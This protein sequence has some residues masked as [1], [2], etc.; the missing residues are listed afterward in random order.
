[1]NSVMYT[2]KGRLRDDLK[3]FEKESGLGP[4]DDR[5]HLRAQTF[6]LVQLCKDMRNSQY[7]LRTKLTRQGNG[8]QTQ[9]V[10]S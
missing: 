6:L 1:M 10:W 4:D 2:L 3:A 9:T 8:W 7:R 5:W